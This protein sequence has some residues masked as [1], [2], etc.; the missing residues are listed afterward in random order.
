MRMTRAGLP[1]ATN[2]ANSRCQLR[3]LVYSRNGAASPL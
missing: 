2:L 3:V 1:G